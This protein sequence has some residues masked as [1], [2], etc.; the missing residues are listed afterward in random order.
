MSERIN[1]CIHCNSQDLDIIEEL[2]PKTTDMNMEVKFKCKKCLYQFI[3]NTK[4]Y[5][6]IKKQNKGFIK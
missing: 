2:N 6:M 5:Y 3:G 1:T 4:S